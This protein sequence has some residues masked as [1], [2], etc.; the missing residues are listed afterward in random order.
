MQ[1]LKGGGY[2]EEGSYSKSRTETSLVIQ[3]LR[4][5]PPNAGGPGWT[6]VQG[7]RSHMLQ[8]DPECYENQRSRGPQLRPVTTKYVCVCVCVCV[9]VLVAHSCLILC[10]PMEFN[11]PGSS[12]HGF[13]WARKL[14]WV[15][16]SLSRG[17]S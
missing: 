1:K 12:V 11:P 16:I 2:F 3:W 17:S 6:P 9:Y 13:L 4:F 7:T 10:D 5:C 14:E 8:L 15:A